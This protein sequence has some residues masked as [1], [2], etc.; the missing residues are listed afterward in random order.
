MRVSARHAFLIPA[1]AAFA[2]LA[3]PAQ[4]GGGGGSGGGNCCT[5]PPPPTCCN[6]G[7]GHTVNVP[8]INIHGGNINVGVNVSSRVNVITN[9]TTNVNASANANASAGAGAG[10]MTFIG[11]GSYTP[12]TTAPAAT[13]ITGL[14]VVGLE[15]EYEYEYYEEERTRW[16]EEWRVVRA[17]CVDDG[18]TPH[19]A[20]RV[21]A[22]ERV[23]AAY[24]GEIYRCM[25]GTAM[26]VTIGWAI[27]GEYDWNDAATIACR[28]GEA[29]RHE[30]GGRLYCEAQEQRRN[31]NERSLLRRHGPG[32]KL[33]YMRREERYTERV[34][35]E[36]ERERRE[37]VS[38]TLMLDGGVGGY[39]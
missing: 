1:S 5:P 34:R 20:S 25:A 31:C 37:R 18:G 32:V 33:V 38:M 6:H 28:K 17:V 8:N 21:D 12:M 27:E 29:L 30:P 7:G 26:Q 19:P 9:V 14:N 10:A 4:A 2:L 22:D 36:V 35:R 24:S 11:G 39:R 16:V 3:A 23:G 13:A 15:E